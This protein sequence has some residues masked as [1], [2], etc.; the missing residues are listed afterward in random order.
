MKVIKKKD[1]GV[2]D[3]LEEGGLLLRV[4]SPKDRGW[5]RDSLGGMDHIEA[6]QVSD[7]CLT[8]WIDNLL[9]KLCKAQSIDYVYD[10]DRLENR[11]SLEADTANIKTTHILNVESKPEIP[12]YDMAGEEEDDHSDAPDDDDGDGSGG[13]PTRLF[14]CNATED[15]KP[16]MGIKVRRKA[17]FHREYRGDYIDIRSNPYLMKALQKL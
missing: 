14:D 16:I 13:M 6:A 1:T 3:G 2:I 9:G 4:L 17:S 15:Q 12:K 8:G 10:F 5:R 7:I 11:S